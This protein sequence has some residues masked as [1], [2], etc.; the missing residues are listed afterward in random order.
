MLCCVIVLQYDDYDGVVIHV[1][2]V[3][4]RVMPIPEK[5]K[6]SMSETFP[7]PSGLT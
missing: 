1:V 6:I 7:R 2:V 5:P 3:D 4:E